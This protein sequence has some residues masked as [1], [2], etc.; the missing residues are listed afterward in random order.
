MLQSGWK[1]VVKR[2]GVDGAFSDRESARW[3]CPDLDRSAR[4]PGE[5]GPEIVAGFTIPDVELVTN[6]RKEHGVG[7][8]Q[9]LPVFDGVKPE[10]RRN[11]RGPAPIPARTVAVLRLGHTREARLLG[12]LGTVIWRQS[13]AVAE[14]EFLHVLGHQVLRLLLKRHQAVF[15]EDHLHALFPELPGLD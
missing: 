14:E 6:Y 15:V 2:D 12:L 4:R 5:S 1:R 8:V 13:R 9:K 11:F 3:A 10:V 7:A